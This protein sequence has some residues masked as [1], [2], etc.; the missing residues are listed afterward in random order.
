MTEIEA[1]P[2]PLAAQV[3]AALV[4]FLSGDPEQ[5]PPLVD[6]LLAE[7]HAAAASDVHLTSRR[8]RLAVSFR[9]S[10]ELTAVA[11]IPKALQDIV[12]QRLKVMARLVVYQ[13]REPQDGRIDT[14]LGGRAVSLRVAFLPTLHGEQVVIRFPDPGR[15]QFGLGQLGM[16]D[17]LLARFTG[18]IERTQGAVLLTGPASCGK[19]TTIYAALRH[20]VA[21]RASD[22]N[23]LTIEDPIEAETE[24]ISQTQVDSGAD[25]DFPRALRAALRHDP[26]VLVVGE[27]RDPVTAQ[28]AIQA[29]LTGHLLIATVHAGSAPGVFTRLAQMGV[30]RYLLAT[31]VSGVL[32]QRL[33]RAVCLSCSRVVRLEEAT[34]AALG[35]S[36]E[37]LTGARVA[38][39]AGCPKCNGTG[40]RGR[41]GLFELLTLT[42]AIRQALLDRA[43][44]IEIADLVHDDGQPTLR[45]DLLAKVRTGV[46]A[47]GEAVRVSR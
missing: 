3:Q 40:S 24:G 46:I 12:I 15:E 10:G 13:R 44:E 41:L 43:T 14:E 25:F 39:G 47:P 18:L 37:E 34:A 33:A 32:N 26:N 23:I 2:S 31:A 5:V 36:P 19:T 42:P 45:D 4:P 11:R 22:L 8:D 16:D 28:T 1:V 7:A 21:T 35:L 29:A 6:R 17:E 27:I 9:I 38:E 20:L 30:E